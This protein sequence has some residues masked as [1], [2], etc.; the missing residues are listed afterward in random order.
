MLLGVRDG[1]HPLGHLD[2]RRIGRDMS[3]SKAHWQ[4]RQ[5]RLCPGSA[6][7]RADLANRE[8]ASRRRSEWCLSELPCLVEVVG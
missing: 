2:P 6:S 3:L 1:D 5:C 8:N 4:L 7:V